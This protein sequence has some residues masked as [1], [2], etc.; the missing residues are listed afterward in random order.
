METEKNQ[1]ESASGMKRCAEVLQA[2]QA[3]AIL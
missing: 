2:M 3:S 1:I